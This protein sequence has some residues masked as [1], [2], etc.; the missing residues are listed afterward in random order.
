[1]PILTKAH[2][3]LRLRTSPGVFFTSALISLVFVVLT[4]AFTTTVDNVFST[5]SGWIMTN[6][7]WF[8]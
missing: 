3:A 6:L 5:A 4:V 2:D 8:Y 7:G 1:M